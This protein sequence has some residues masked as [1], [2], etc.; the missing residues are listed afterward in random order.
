MSAP[1]CEN[2]GT[3]FQLL[4]VPTKMTPLLKMILNVEETIVKDRF[5]ND[6]KTTFVRLFLGFIFPFLSVFLQ[7]HDMENHKELVSSIKIRKMK[8]FKH[9]SGV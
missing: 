1:F 2:D 6:V 5:V 3:S 7:E 4:P 8:K 9:E